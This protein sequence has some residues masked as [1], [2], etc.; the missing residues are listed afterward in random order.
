MHSLTCPVSNFVSPASRRGE[1]YTRIVDEV[2]MRTSI[3]VCINLPGVNQFVLDSVAE[4][5]VNALSSGWS[6][7]GL[8]AAD[9]SVSDSFVRRFLTE[10]DVR[11]PVTAS[12]VDVVL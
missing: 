2:H 11:S 8:L 10:A 9:T 4:S 7:R 1:L 3:F 6:I 5:E 12:T